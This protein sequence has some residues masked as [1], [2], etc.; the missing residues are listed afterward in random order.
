MFCRGAFFISSP[1]DVSGTEEA[2]GKEK[3]PKMECTMMR[4][5]WAQAKQVCDC[6]RKMEC[7]LK[8][9]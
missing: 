3:T 2:G 9:R 4:S 5:F 8:H 1:V 7:Y 6:H